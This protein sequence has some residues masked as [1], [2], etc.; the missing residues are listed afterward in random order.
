MDHTHQATQPESESYTYIL[1]LNTDKAHQEAMT[2]LR[3]QYFPPK[4]NKTSA[5]I[6]LFRGLPGSELPSI[7][8]A[9]QD[10]VSHQHPFP[11]A[12]GKAV[13]HTRGV[14]L[15]VHVAPAQDIFQTLKA[16]W[17]GFLR[18]QDKSFR[19]LY[20]IQNKVEDEKL[21]QK[22][23]E[24][25]QRNFAG[26]TGT[27][28]GLKLYVYNGGHWV[29]QRYYLFQKDNPENN[30]ASPKVTDEELPALATSPRRSLHYRTVLL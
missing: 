16:R 12:T 8:S 20:V 11:I 24:E 30:T 13:R 5:Q 29:F 22:T 25:V 19:P 7:V 9:I 18:E 10:V 15:E 23:F 14:G 28:T 2:A 27:V 6:A 4:L 21:V 17:Q 26:S 1:A 3:N